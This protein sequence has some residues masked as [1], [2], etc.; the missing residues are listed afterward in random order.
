MASIQ[1]YALCA[2]VCETS[3]GARQDV[4]QGMYNRCF[5]AHTCVVVIQAWC[6]ACLHRL[7]ALCLSTSMRA[8]P[9]STW[10]SGVAWNTLSQPGR[11]RRRCAGTVQDR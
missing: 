6:G 7:T 4:F 5:P 11:W 10:S 9:P 2:D 8:S 1:M 3:G